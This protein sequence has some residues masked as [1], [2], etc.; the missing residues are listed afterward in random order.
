MVLRRNDGPCLLHRCDTALWRSIRIS[1]MPVPPILVKK[2]MPLL[3]PFIMVSWLFRKN[4]KSLFISR[5]FHPGPK[6][7][8]KPTTKS[9]RQ[10]IH[11]AIRDSC[12]KGKVDEPLRAKA[13]EALGRTDG[14]HFLVLFREGQFKGL[15][16]F[17][18]DANEASKFFGTGPSRID[19]SMTEKLLQW[20]TKLYQTCIF[21]TSEIVDFFSLLVLSVKAL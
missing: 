5:C 2:S 17:D 3:V 7:F 10:I 16:T 20:V 21:W 1:A 6:L 11:N 14:C 19:D 8:K 12:L 18:P 4:R 15:Y 13:L 9:N